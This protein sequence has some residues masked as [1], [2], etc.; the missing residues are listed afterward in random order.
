MKKLIFT[1][2]ILCTSFSL[3]QPKFTSYSD[4]NP[5]VPKG[6]LMDWDRSSLWWPNVSFIQDT[7]YLTYLG[8]DNFPNSPLS[9]GLATSTDGYNYTKHPTPI[10]EA[11]GTNIELLSVSNGP[12]FKSDVTWHL[13]YNGISTDPNDPGRVIARA[14]S[15]SP[16]GPWERENDTL[17]T[18]GNNGEW[19][20]AFVLPLSII[21]KNTDLVMYYFGGDL[22]PDPMG[23]IGMATSSDG[24]STWE[25]YIGNPIL[26]PGPE[27][28][29]NI[30]IFGAS[31][32]KVGNKWEM[33][34]T[35]ENNTAF[36]ICYA[37]S[38]DGTN[39]I[40]DG[41][42]LSPLGDPLAVDLY[43]GPSVVRNTDG[44]FL[45]YDYG[46][47]QAGIGLA[48]AENLSGIIDIPN[49]Y[50]S[51]QEGINT[52]SDG[53]TVLVAEGTYYENINFKGKAITVASHFILDQDTS[54]ISKTIIDGSQPSDANKESVVTFNSGED[55]NSVICGF[56][57]TGGSGTGTETIRGG[58]ILVYN[59]TAKISNNI[60]KE[61]EIHAQNNKSAGGGICCHTE[62]PT[63]KVVIISGNTIIYNKAI[64]NVQ[65]GGYG[66]GI[67]VRVSNVKAI[68]NTISFNEAGGGE[69][70][71][72]PGIRI[73][74][75]ESSILDSNTISF[76]YH[77]SIS[78]LSGG[79][80][81]VQNNDV[82]V[83][84][85]HFEGNTST[86][87]GGIC[88]Y[89]SNNSIISD[90]DFINNSAEQRGGGIQVQ[91]NAII[92]NNYFSG[93]TAGVGSGI[94][95]EES[96]PLIAG[97]IIINNNAFGG[98]SISCFN[99]A[100]PRIQNNLITKNKGIDGG[101]IAIV[102][103]SNPEIVNNTI[104]ENTAKTGGGLTLGTNCD[105]VI[106]NT[107]LYQN[108]ADS[109]GSQVF[110]WDE[111]CE[112]SFAYC[113]IEGGIANFGIYENAFPFPGTYENNIDSDPMFFDADS[114]HLS[115]TSPCRNTGN[116]DP[117]YNDCDESSNDMGWLGGPGV[118]TSINKIINVTGELP[119]SYNFAQNYPNPFNPSTTI[120]YSIPNVASGFSLS[121]VVLKIYDILG[122]EVTT[123]VN[124]K[125]KPG[126]YEVTWDA[127]NQTSGVYFY[128]LVAGDFRETRKMILLR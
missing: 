123:L 56:T 42:I 81:L 20:D 93:N 52:A 87:G 67:D 62:F 116:P 89:Q 27:N 109:S 105:P 5:V 71:Y 28:Y 29:D 57:I 96:N 11:N 102:V 3:A 36:S 26:S 30:S 25:K 120:K 79:L 112:P 59:S 68:N 61:N 90:N 58:G 8:T 23:Q 114:F 1:I 125:Q 50:S 18:V 7:F 77:S 13:Y 66:G 17:L 43:E 110:I 111:Q 60:I 107:I 64:T 40:K 118:I 48:T 6:I 127:G 38:I 94:S 39:W 63:N 98:G 86:V 119:S 76:N 51:I 80:F 95:C 103:N 22:W 9:V 104:V 32:L 69:A 92:K 70:C 101:G 65:P 122:R 108:T 10:L 49:Q 53:D 34:Y 124:Q 121:N 100:N 106:I 99:F 126:F 47:R 4:G 54:H 14:N 75:S 117:A 41:V 46:L 31:I 113:D 24:G 84:N 82:K 128:Q 78:S 73:A 12:I 45:Y 35:G 33:F 97:N 19:D 37:T 72:G 91:A 115:E 83:R 2:F 44:Y 16:Y 55:T 15:S 88:D 85:N 74:H 21:K